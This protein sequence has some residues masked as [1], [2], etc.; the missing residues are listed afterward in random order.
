M[1]RINTY[2]S[3]DQHRT[4]SLSFAD[5]SGGI[6]LR[7]SNYR[8][9]ANESP[10]VVNLWWED[11]FLQSRPGRSKLTVRSSES[12]SPSGAGY[13]VTRDTYYGFT[14]A[15][16]GT[17]L[18]Y[19][20][21]DDSDNRL[22]VHPFA[23]GV[24]ASAG[25]FF[26]FG[27]N[28]FYKNQG[29]FYRIT[30][31]NNTLSA[32]S[33]TSANAYVPTIVINAN[34]DDGSGD[35]YQPENRLSPDK[36]IT[37]NA[38]TTTTTLTMTADG[39]QKVFPFQLSTDEKNRFSAVTNV[40]ADSVYQSPA[41]YEATAEQI[42]FSEAPKQGAVILVDIALL[43]DTYH[44]PVKSIDRVISVSV[45]GE[46]VPASAYTVNA[47]DGTVTF[48]TGSIPPVTSPPTNNT[49]SITYRKANSD[50]YRSILQCRYAAVYGTGT[51]LCIVFAGYPAQPNAV[52]WSGNTSA[53]LDPTYF[54]A[55]Y[56]NFVGDA[57]DPVTALAAQYDDLIVFK[58]RSV[59]KFNA[60]YQDVDGR[61][62]VSLAYESINDRIGCDLPHSVQLIENNLVFANTDGGNYGGGVFMIQ[63][64]S[65]AYENNIISICDKIKGSETARGLIYDMRAGSDAVT[66]HD[67]GKRYYLCVNRH[68]WV[69]D[70]MSSKPSDP[71]WWYWTGFD[72][73]PWFQ[74]KGVMYQLGAAGDVSRLDRS[75]SDFGEFIP[76]VYQF[77]VQTFGGYGRLK[78]I[79]TLLISVAGDTPHDT[80]II[81]QTDYEQ[82]RDLTNL[83][84]NGSASLAPRDLSFRD[85]S[86]NNFAVSFVR[87]PKCRHVRHFSLRLE[88]NA[89]GQDLSVLSAEIQYRFLGKDR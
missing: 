5:L 79:L 60:S 24:P 85:L 37:Y 8:L 77:P 42:A 70:Y 35:L 36:T 58:S 76:K 57:E 40:T 59:G 52:F 32:A 23:S 41:Q 7:D 45:D 18:W 31:A 29:A 43:V 54:P 75:L 68:V 66:S 6:N 20:S 51:Q 53:G 62:S 80:T 64:A 11:G 56:Y 27:E 21:Y 71:V 9:K 74:R 38:A 67:D 83:V 15:H 89:A 50:F 1:K 13:A 33:V 61:T 63:S 82:R 26:R 73:L 69:W 81:Y 16:I 49:V 19:Y 14:V 86:V 87:R 55:D 65:A 4:Q 78:D 48:K 39:A 34:P 84:S 25:T 30:Y 3:P 12:V 2:Y 10:E 88:N 72:A 28:L 46:T 22:I 44:L 47:S 17:R